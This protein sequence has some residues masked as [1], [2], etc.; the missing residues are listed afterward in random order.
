MNKKC[1]ESV[2]EKALDEFWSIIAREFPEATS[3]DLSVEATVNLENTAKRA[4]AVW[5]SNNV[6][7]SNRR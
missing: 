2:T 7:A 1:L 3:G 6:P 4:I 5:I